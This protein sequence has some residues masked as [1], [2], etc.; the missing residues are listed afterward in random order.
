MRLILQ[1]DHSDVL[2]FH[3]SVKKA[4]DTTGKGNV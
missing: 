2:I 3:I 1:K 4:M